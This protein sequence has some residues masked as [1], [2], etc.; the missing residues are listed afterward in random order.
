MFKKDQS[1]QQVIP[2]KVEWEYMTFVETGRGRQD[3]HVDDWLNDFGEEGWELV[4]MIPK[5]YRS[6]EMKQ[7]HPE[8][9]DPWTYI[10]K[11]PVD[12]S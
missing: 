6:L 11:R 5:D 9:D 12:R 3:R 1:V 8:V 4:Q 2:A 10:F 7:E